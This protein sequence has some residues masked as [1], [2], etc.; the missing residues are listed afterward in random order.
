MRVACIF[1][2]CE[3]VGHRRSCRIFSPWPGERIG[4]ICTAEAALW[5]CRYRDVFNLLNEDMKKSIARKHPKRKRIRRRCRRTFPHTLTSSLRTERDYVTGARLVYILVCSIH[6]MLETAARRQ[7]TTT[8]RF[9]CATDPCATLNFLGFE[10]RCE[11][12]PPSASQ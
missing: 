9:A 3:F 10:V 7:R 4:I 8:H 1:G 6:I 5:K 11:S 12:S 2:V